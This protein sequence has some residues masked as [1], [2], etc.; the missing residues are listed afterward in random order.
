MS[1][2]SAISI[3][4]IGI[5]LMLAITVAVSF[6]YWSVTRVQ[7]STN[8]VTTGNLNVT[9]SKEENA[10]NLEN[11]YPISDE[12]A[13]GLTPFT[14][15]I[16]NEGDT[17]ASYTANLEMLAGT[18]LSS[19]FIATKLNAGEIKKLSSY[20][21]STKSIASS[22]GSKTIA[23]GGLEPGE[24][25]TYQLRLWMDKDTTLD[26]DAQNKTF[27][28]KIVVLAQATTAPNTP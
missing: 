20:Q 2:K 11:A 24:S 26:D 25:I 5:M 4:V 15:T 12:A 17:Y 18:T 7:E 21:E 9:I 13:D 23:T 14:F 28:A 10:I 8:V 27:E 6:A 16:T 1:K 22:V 3:T 19:N